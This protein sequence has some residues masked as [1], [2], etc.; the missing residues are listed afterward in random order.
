MGIFFLFFPYSLRRTTSYFFFFLTLFVVEYFNNWR[1]FS[2]GEKE[3]NSNYFLNY[4]E[5]Y[6]V[7]SQNLHWTFCSTRLFLEELEQVEGLSSIS[8]KVHK[9]IDEKESR[10]AAKIYILSINQ[11]NS[12]LKG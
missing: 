6:T 7:K 4:K 11:Y 12:Q 10:I 1:T 3:Y 8:G 9:N 2:T 5:L